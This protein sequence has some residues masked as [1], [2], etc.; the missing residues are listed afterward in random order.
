MA[1]PGVRGLGRRLSLPS[2]TDRGGRA[3]EESGRALIRKIATE[4]TVGPTC[5]PTAI[6]ARRIPSEAM[7][8]LRTATQVA[9][10][11]G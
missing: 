11:G 1:G 2:V 9:P 4:P 6:A 5:A 7:R 8:A 3:A 10:R